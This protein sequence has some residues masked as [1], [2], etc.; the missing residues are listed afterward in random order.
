MWSATTCVAVGFSVGLWHSKEVDEI[1]S[2]LKIVDAFMPL[3]L[4]FVS[5][6]IWKMYSNRR[7]DNAT[8]TNETY[9]KEK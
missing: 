4:I 7:H 6:A 3:Y 9:K 8:E 5:A 1:N 2:F